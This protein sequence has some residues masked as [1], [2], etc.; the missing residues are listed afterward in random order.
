VG[1]HLFSRPSCTWSFVCYGDLNAP[2]HASLPW[3]LSSPQ[4]RH[5][6]PIHD[7]DIDHDRPPMSV[8]QRVKALDPAQSSKHNMELPGVTCPGPHLYYA[9]PRSSGVVVALKCRCTTTLCLNLILPSALSYP[10]VDPSPPPLM[11][12]CIHAPCCTAFPSANELSLPSLLQ[13]IH[14]ADLV[15]PTTEPYSHLRQ[16]ICAEPQG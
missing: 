7:F 1:L 13:V 5:M 16:T 11:G 3:A 4:V 6:A 12:L 2:C 14:A 15:Q 8:S 10:I 9:A